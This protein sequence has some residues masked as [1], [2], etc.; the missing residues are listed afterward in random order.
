ML[1][2]LLL[3]S[4]PVSW[5]NTAYPFAAA[6]LLAGGGT[7]AA[8]IVGSLFFL[9]PYNLAM[10]G[11]N[12][13]FDYE[14]D[15]R[16]PRK[17]GAEGHIAAPTTHRMILTAAAIACIPFVVLLVAFGG[18]LSTALL[19]VS[20]AAVVAYSAPRLR[21]KEIPLLDSLTSSTHF[22]SPAWFGIALALA[23][24]WTGEAR[25]P[26][27]AGSAMPGIDIWLVLVAFFV[28]GAAAQAFGAVQDI[29][30]DREAGL[31][32]I[33]TVIGARATVRLAT[34]AFLAAGVSVAVAGFFTGLGP[35]AWLLGACGLLALPYAANTGR[36]A[37]V[38]DED[39][40]RTRGGWKVFLWLNYCVGFLVT[41]ALIGMVTL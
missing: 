17:G 4:R 41:L 9:V 2:E 21:F 19:A 33:A 6:Y 8:W 40:E 13:V 18:P 38:T 12:D 27:E 36:F 20:L 32:S 15:L 31:G 5:V 14:S 11:I 26:A 39:A 1:R 7:D 22:S 34:L 29:A 16:N 23:P 3:A 37:F 30:P 25:L 35:Q 24:T 28:W 10:Y